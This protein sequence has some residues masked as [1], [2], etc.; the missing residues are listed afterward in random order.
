MASGKKPWS[1]MNW[2]MPTQAL[3]HIGQHGNIPLIPS[4]LSPAGQDFCR[5]CLI[6]NP[7]E[8]PSAEELLKHP[9]IATVDP[10]APGE[11]GEDSTQ[12]AELNYFV[13]KQIQLGQGSSKDSSSL[14]STHAPTTLPLPPPAQANDNPM[15]SNDIPPPPAYPHPDDLPPPPPPAPVESP[16]KGS[17]T[18]HLYPF[19]NA[20]APMAVLDKSTGG[21]LSLS[22]VNGQL[23]QAVE[24]LNIVYHIPID[25]NP[26]PFTASGSNSCS[27][28]NSVRTNPESRIFQYE[29]Y[30]DDGTSSMSMS[31]SRISFVDEEF[32]IAAESVRS[33]SFRPQCP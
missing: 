16:S 2:T 22:H 31:M 9:F 27:N 19:T 6:R 14:V 7:D 11:V 17:P 28:S 4:N 3:F 20:A 29:P 26:T 13:E 12:M 18:S 5:K 8:R 10:M 15:D 1:E 30:S 24:Q 33:T 25:K 21:K 32:Q 23:T